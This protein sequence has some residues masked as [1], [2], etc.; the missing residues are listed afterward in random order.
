[1]KSMFY[2]CSSLKSI[3]LSSFNTN[4]VN[5]ISYMFDGCSSLKKENVILNKNE[6][7]ILDELPEDC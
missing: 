6:K 2:K 1:M 4:N 7:K 5:N 3:Y